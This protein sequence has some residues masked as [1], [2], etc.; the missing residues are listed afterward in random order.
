[1]TD[2]IAT[3][4]ERSAEPLGGVGATIGW[5]LFGASS[6][7]WC[8]GMFLPTILLARFGWA[9]FW[10]FLIPNVLGCA[11]FGYFFGRDAS[12]RFAT[13]HAAAIRWF[14]LATI[15]FQV[16]FIGWACDAFVFAPT[17]AAETA[18]ED[19]GIAG[20]VG[21]TLTWPV[22]GTILTWTAAAVALGARSDRFWRW[23]ATAAAVTSATLFAF[24]LRRSGGLPEAPTP[25]GGASL[26]AAIPVI[27][28]GF[29]A[30]P[31]LDATFHRMRQQSPSRHSFAVF[32]LVFTGM[33][34]LAAAT[35]DGLSP[36]NLAE[37][38]LPLA[39][40]QWTLQLVF[41]IGAPAREVPLLPGGRLASG[42]A[43]A[44]AVAIGAITGLPGLAGEPVYLGYLGLYA[45]PFPMY[46]IAAVVAGEH[47]LRTRATPTVIVLSILL[48]PLGWIGF[49]DN[50]T[51]ALLPVAAGTAIAGWLIGRFQ[52]RRGLPDPAL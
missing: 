39:I 37:A 21:D 7:T 16:F 12:R 40:A 29:L 48:A 15:S 18:I 24:A 22:L 51:T 13:R 44:M 10:A 50:R 11:G 19:A 2:A 42:P 17:V 8:I 20:A 5:G 32:G 3:D 31:A 34:L 33:L 47:P 1:M 28:L 41:T 35:F 36:R 27:T 25:E 26:L 23:F 52:S 46:A 45:I 6:W 49:V 43:I 9:G 14:S 38:V 4:D 30:C